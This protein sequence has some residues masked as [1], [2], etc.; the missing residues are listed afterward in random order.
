MKHFLS[1]HLIVRHRLTTVWLEKI[2]DAGI[3]A[4]ELFCAKQHLDWHD[5]G[6]IR[7]LGH[8]FRA[9][10]LQVHSIHSPMYT[11]DVWGRSGPQSV[12]N[13]TEPVKSKRLAVVDEI[14][15]ALDIAEI[16]PFRY[17]IQHLGV[18]GEEYDERRLD[19]AF[20]A[21][22]EISLFAKQRGVE[23]LLEN[24]QNAF[25]SA[26]R[27]LMFN[28]ITHLNLNF[29]FDVGHANMGEGVENAFRLLKNR[30]RSTHIHDNN[31]TEDQHLFPFLSPGGTIDW[32]QAMDLLRS[33]GDQ[34][35]LLLELREAPDMAQPLEAVKRVLE[36][37]ETS[38]AANER[39]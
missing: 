14:K 2:R 19:A 20:T 28:E 22:E 13:I 38:T 12:L 29:C 24:I 8:W 15:R 36:R 1:T 31:G 27:L 16:V 17:L 26:E 21:L 30:I 32:K 11:D 39:E 5:E 10:E 25:S 7:E 9:S 18:T 33:G 23:V 3:P 6:Q 35:P 34:I 37:L 4:I